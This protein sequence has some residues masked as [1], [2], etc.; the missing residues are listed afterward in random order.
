MF[1]H[2]KLVTKLS[3]LSQI[4]CHS[5]LSRGCHTWKPPPAALASK[6]EIEVTLSLSLALFLI[7]SLADKRLIYSALSIRLLNFAKGECNLQKRHEEHDVYL[8]TSLYPASLA[9]RH[10]QSYEAMAKY[11]PL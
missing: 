6:G 10:T 9:C 1:D 11:F 3:L 5:A 8:L 4:I 2:I 7:L